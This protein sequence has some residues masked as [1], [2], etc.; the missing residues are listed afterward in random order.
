MRLQIMEPLVII[1]EEPGTHPWTHIIN[2]EDLA[3]AHNRTP[4][5]LMQY[6]KMSLNSRGIIENRIYGSYCPLIIKCVLQ[7]M[8][9]LDMVRRGY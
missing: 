2:I 1:E 4:D 7:V 9:Y 5:Q 3:L 6:L 8:A